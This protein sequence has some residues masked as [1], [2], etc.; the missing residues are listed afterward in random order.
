MALNISLKNFYHIICFVLLYFSIFSHPIGIIELTKNPL[1]ISAIPYIVFTTQFLLFL[2]EWSSNS[3]NLNLK[4]NYKLF[5]IITLFFS[6]LLGLLNA[7]FN[8]KLIFNYTN[9]EA[10]YYS[11]SASGYLLLLYNN[12]ENYNFL[13]KA[14]IIQIIILL[15]VLLTFILNTKQITYGASLNK[16]KIEL[17]NFEKLF[18]A[19]SNGLGRISLILSL[20]FLIISISQSKLNYFIFTISTFFGGISLA[21]EGK[22][23]TIMLIFLIIYIIVNSNYKNKI[24][25]LTFYIFFSLTFYI[26]NYN[27]QR[28]KIEKFHK[29]QTQLTK[30]EKERSYSYDLKQF[31]H[32]IFRINNIQNNNDNIINLIRSHPNYGNFQDLIENKFQKKINDFF[33]GRLNKYIF[34]FLNNQNFVLGTGPMSDRT[35]ANINGYKVNNDSASAITYTYLTSGIFGLILLLYL[36]YNLIK[37]F[38][39]VKIEQVQL[40]KIYIKSLILLILMRSL[41]ENSFTVWGIDFCV[42]LLSIVTIEYFSKKKN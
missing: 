31:K 8:N 21:F 38:F 4:S 32:N 28:F 18:V 16:I 23:N 5:L 41:I 34:F 14:N 10:V 26:I 17:L 36:Y 22:F 25:L 40:N 37:I 39:Y 20:F 12:R 27:Y 13:H 15:L 2:R 29:D 9:L 19:N 6:Q 42:L 35:I 1:S 11:I 24:Y 7:Y 33:T 30:E 3:L